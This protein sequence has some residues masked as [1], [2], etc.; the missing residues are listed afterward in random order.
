LFVIPGIIKGIAYSQMFYLMADN[1]NMEPDEA[2]ARSIEMMSGHKMELF[3][4]YLSFL[5]WLLFVI[6]T[7]GIGLIYVAPYISATMA[8]YY[9]YVKKASR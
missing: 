7:L 8:A 1:P 2:Q 9:R 3:R 4:L 6:V 5:P